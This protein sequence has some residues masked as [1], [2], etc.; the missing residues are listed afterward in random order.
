MHHLYIIWEDFRNGVYWNLHAQKLDKNGNFFWQ[1]G[2]LDIFANVEENHQNPNIVPDGY[3]GMLFVYQKYSSE[4]HGTDIYRGRLNSSGELLFHFATCYSQDEQLNPVIMKKGSKALLCWEDRRNGNWDLYAQMIRLNDGILEWDVNGVPVIKTDADERNPVVITA[5]SYG[6]QV[7]S[8]LQRS[9]KE[10]KVYVQKLNNLGEPA[11]GE[12]GKEVCATSRSQTEPAIWPDAEGGLW[13]SWTD[14]RDPG[15]AHIYLQHVNGLGRPLLRKEGSKMA[16]EHS[17]VWAKLAGLKILAAR[18]GHFFVVWEDFRSGDKD[19]DLYIQKLDQRGKPVWRRGGI[20]VCLAPGEQ[21]RPV[22]VEDGVGGVIVSWADRR[23]MRDDNIYAQRISAWGKMLWRS[24][25]VQ[26]CGAASD[27]NSIRAISDGK[28]GI[29]LCWVDARTLVETGFDLYIQRIGHDGASL[30]R[31][32]GK[33]FARYPGLQSAPSLVSDGQGGAYI[34]WM[35]ARSAHSNIYVQH[36]DEF[37]IYE[38]EYGGRCPVPMSANQRN[39]SLVRNRTGDLFLAWQEG[40]FGDGFEK[41]F[42][43]CITPNG[44]KLWDRYGIQVCN[45]PGRQARP[46]LAVDDYGNL[47][48][49]WLDERNRRYAGVQLMAQKYDIGGEVKWQDDGVKLGESMEEWNPYGITLDAKGNFYAIWNQENASEH[50]NIFYQKINPDGAKKFGYGG[51]R[52]GGEAE[53][54]NAPIGIDGDCGR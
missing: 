39:P 44:R 53:H 52:M 45:H 43:Q 8:W 36:I 13:C 16:A 11:W 9:G 41:L 35:D 31:K 15:S 47:W 32:D 38:W 50:R 30:W 19:P 34:A 12:E 48:V 42:L 46:K 28:E 26:V 17:Q 29:V 21:S 7:F 1:A 6:Y 3:G 2:G 24:D 18:T 54:Q 27:Q 20:P 51:N 14:R 10:T 23:N 40:R 37:G 25:G 22:L 5:A 4:T 49:A 33:P